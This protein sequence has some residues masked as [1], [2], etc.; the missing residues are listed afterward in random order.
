[1]NADEVLY[2]GG[3]WTEYFP[4]ELFFPQDPRLA[5][6]LMFRD[7]FLSDE[8]KIYAQ[9]DDL[10]MKKYVYFNVDHLNEVLPFSDFEVSLRA[11]PTEVMGFIGIALSLVAKQL[12]P[13]FG[14]YFIIRP[15]FYGL[16]GDIMFGDLKSNTV[17]QMVSIKGHVVRVSACRPLVECGSFLCAKCM[18]YTTCK[19]ED[20][21]FVPPLVCSTEKLVAVLIPWYVCLHNVS[22]ALFIALQVL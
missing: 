5:G 4:K 3:I 18:K 17:G 10:A 11:R 8:G 12:H 13:F 1:M 20:G 9:K 19:F 21:I 2:V 15:R 16:K 14:D 6:V 7:F 22:I